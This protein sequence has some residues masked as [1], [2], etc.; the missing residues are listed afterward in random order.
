MSGHGAQ[1]VVARVVQRCR[2]WAVSAKPVF[3]ERATRNLPTARHPE[4]VRPDSS[5]ARRRA[6]SLIPRRRPDPTS[7]SANG[8]ALSARLP[9]EEAVSGKAAELEPPNRAGDPRPARVIEV[10]EGHHG[11]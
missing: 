1:A 10:V 4:K 6:S 11:V 8:R 5:Q 3:L 9:H 7:D 2:M